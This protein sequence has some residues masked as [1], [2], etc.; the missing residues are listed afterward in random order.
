MLK[1]FLLNLPHSFSPL[2]R[3]YFQAAFVVVD[4]NMI[5]CYNSFTV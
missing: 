4:K 1:P 5:L 3:K 2:S